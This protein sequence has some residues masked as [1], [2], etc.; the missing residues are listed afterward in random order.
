MGR[1][2]QLGGWH[3]HAKPLPD[4]GPPA[5]CPRLHGAPRGA[6][7]PRLLWA[8]R[9]HHWDPIPRTSCAKRLG[10]GNRVS[11][12]KTHSSLNWHEKTHGKKD[13]PRL[14]STCGRPRLSGLVLG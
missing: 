3:D 7:P 1:V 5:S 4:Q 10:S 2:G 8:A 6:P 9:I 11:Y 14:C 12:W 13:V